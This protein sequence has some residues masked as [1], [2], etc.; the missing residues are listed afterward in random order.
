MQVFGGE[1]LGKR[2]LRKARHT[3]EDNINTDLQEVG[4][5]GERGLNRSN[6]G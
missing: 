5:R 4:W 2:P 6:L 3:W 1:T